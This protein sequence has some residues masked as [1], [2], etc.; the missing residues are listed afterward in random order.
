MAARRK[1]KKSA[2][3]SSRGLAPHQVVAAAPQAVQEL[4]GTIESDGGRVI[5]CY[6]DPLGGAWQ[7]LACLPIE[8]VEP[9]PFQR[10][11]SPAHV[12]RLV[13]RIGA[14]GRF[15]DP[16]ICVR[17]ADG[18]YWTPNGH[19]RTAALREL[20]ARSIVA[21]VVP[22][23]ELAFQ[24][25]SLNTE[26]AHNLRE[27][28][29]EVIR[30]ARELARLDPGR[31]SD[32][33][34]VFEEPAFLTLGVSYER[35]GRFS[36]GAYHP[37]LKRVEGFLDLKLARAL[38]TREARASRLLELDDAVLRAVEALR[39]RGFESPYLKVFVI[40][41]L[42]PLR[43][44]RSAAADFDETLE[45]MLRAAS[46]FDASKIRSEQ[47]ARSGGPPEE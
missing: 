12:E 1:R 35:R 3:P 47:V 4:Q 45:K 34:A 20:G 37:L 21:L 15:L 44:Q 41:R 26:K 17:G 9:T 24:I 23:R 16:I 33:A 42:N 46:R 7:C 13:Q 28:S 11:L 14:L 27:K 6:R 18:R 22:E 36:G 19:H 25:L 5:G 2:E 38:E 31:E 8:R 39:G 29:L 40:A 10:D 43:F 32:H 30:M